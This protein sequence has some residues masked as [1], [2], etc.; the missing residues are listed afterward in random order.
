[1]PKK[2]KSAYADDAV[3]VK[4]IAEDPVPA[5]PGVKCHECGNTMQIAE[6]VFVGATLVARRYVCGCRGVLKHFN[7]H[8]G[9]K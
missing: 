7:Q 6:E 8:L 3:P 2:K 4:P 5:E 9:Q 1:M